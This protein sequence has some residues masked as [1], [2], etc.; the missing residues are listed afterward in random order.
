VSSDSE[1]TSLPPETPVIRPGTNVRRA[2]FLASLVVGLVVLVILLPGRAWA[3]LW[4]EVQAQWALVGMIFVF[5]LIALSLVWS[6]GQSLDIWV[7]RRFNLYG[8]RPQWL[9]RFMWLAT[10]LGNMVAALV[11]ACVFLVLSDRNLAVE[12]LLGTLSLWLLVEGIKALTRRDRPF[13]GLEGTQV[14]GRREPGRSFPSGHTA[15]I[16]FLVTVISHQLALGVGIR[17]ALYGVAV[18]VGITRVYVGVHYPRDVLGG[19]V[20]GCLWGILVGLLDVYML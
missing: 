12:I 17:V 7:F 6:A 4:S 5:T 13:L 2:V 1:A 8:Y 15:Q 9:D 10:Q 11:L 18:L 16:F 19:A 20:L 14:V 3:S